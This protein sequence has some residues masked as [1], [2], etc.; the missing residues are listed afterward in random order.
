MPGM[1]AYSILAEYNFIKN[2]TVFVHS[3]YPIKR[4]YIYFFVNYS[5][6]NSYYWINNNQADLK[7]AE[8]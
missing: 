3:I 7:V 1:Q 4:I 2:N 5:N 6:R 8:L